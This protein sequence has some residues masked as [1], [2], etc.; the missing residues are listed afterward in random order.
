MNSCIQMIKTFTLGNAPAGLSHTGRGKWLPQPKN[1]FT[2]RVIKQVHFQ[3]LGHESSLDSGKLSFKAVPLNSSFL[4]PLNRTVINHK[5][6]FVT[7]VTKSENA[8]PL[9]FD[10]P[11]LHS[12]IFSLYKEQC[13][14]K[15]HSF[16]QRYN[17]F[18]CCLH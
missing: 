10:P 5:R 2:N 6:D 1:T 14:E 13:R 15:K 17:I 12:H 3:H 11:N 8:F 7:W 4:L 9:G 18:L 16:V